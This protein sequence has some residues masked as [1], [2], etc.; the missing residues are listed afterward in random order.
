MTYKQGFFVMFNLL[1]D[2]YLE[3]VNNNDLAILLSS[4]N[5][6][7]FEG[8]YSAD[9]AYW[10]DWK[11][12]L[13]EK[14]IK[15]PISTDSLLDMICSFLDYYQREFEFNLRVVIE[16]INELSKESELL[17][18]YMKQAEAEQTDCG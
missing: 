4:M 8:S 2:Y 7:L 18:K 6:G 5:P 14:A 9:P 12:I 13:R 1:D 15:E 11:R 3:D 16:K 17:I 10:E